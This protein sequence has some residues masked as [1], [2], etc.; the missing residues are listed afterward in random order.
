MTVWSEIRHGSKFGDWFMPPVIIDYYDGIKSAL[1]EVT[2]LSAA[3]RFDMRAWDSDQDVRVYVVRSAPQALVH[4]VAQD[5][6]GSFVGMG[7]RNTSVVEWRSLG[8]ASEPEALV[9]SSD[10]LGTLS[11]VRHLALREERRSVSA[12]ELES[13]DIGKWLLQCHRPLDRDDTE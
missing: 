3:Y 12:L 11:F 7:S 13:D 5:L 1:A 10:G 6:A 9:I 4:R 2:T 8:S